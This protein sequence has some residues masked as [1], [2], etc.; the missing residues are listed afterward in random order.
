MATSVKLATLRIP[1]EI[2]DELQDLAQEDG[3]SLNS[4]ILSILESRLE[5]ESDD[6]D[7]ED[8]DDDSADEA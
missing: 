8:S 6:D 3:V 7:S 2:F 4:Y 5:D 1:S